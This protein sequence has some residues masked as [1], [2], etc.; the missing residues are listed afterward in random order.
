[1]RSARGKAASLAALLITGPVWSLGS[2]LTCLTACDAEQACEGDDCEAKPRARKDAATA[3]ATEAPPRVVVEGDAVCAMQ[4]IRATRGKPKPVDVVFVIDNSGSM[5]E[6]IAA[7]RENI[8]R[9]FADIIDKSGVDYRVIM[10]SRYENDE[11]PGATGICIAPPLAGGPCS[12]GSEDAFCQLLA[13]F[14]RPDAMGVA[15]EGWQ[16]WL[17]PDAHK[18][19]VVITDDSA[20]CQYLQGEQ[21]VSFGGFG[22]DPFADALNFHAALLARSPEQ[23]G[24]PPDV[25]YQFFSI[26]GMAQNQPATDPYFPQDGL[27]TA[28]CDTAPSAG[29]AYQALSIATDALRYPVCEGRSFDTVFRALANSVIQA[30]KADCIFDL[31]DA[32]MWSVIDTST[33]NLEFRSGADGAIQQFS[34]VATG[35]ECKDDA[36]SFYIRERIELCPAA[37]RLV[38]AD[39]APEINIQYGC[40]AIPQ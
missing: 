6:E 31:P 19:L 29:L 1:M 39:P 36:Q 30:S 23:F 17:R 18:S 10:L 35:R 12:T 8:N 34:Q 20:R 21:P 40:A 16:A 27:T 2:A 37:C 3:D 26:V 33:V 11:S 4:S 28:M 7:V 38:Q 5:S 15:P 9:D 22:S 14:D 24:V 25:K 32:P 13:T